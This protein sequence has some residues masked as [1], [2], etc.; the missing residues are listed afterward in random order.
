MNAAV[1]KGE[2]F[3]VVFNTWYV[4]AE[5]W[6]ALV[7]DGR[8]NAIQLYYGT[9]MVDLFLIDKSKCDKPLTLVLEKGNEVGYPRLHCTPWPPPRDRVSKDFL[10]Q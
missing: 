1:E 10:L 2:P 4:D 8:G 9:G 3:F 7:A 5:I 6:Q